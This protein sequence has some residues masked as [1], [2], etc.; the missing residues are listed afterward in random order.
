MALRPPGAGPWRR[1][2]PYL[3]RYRRAF[4]IGFLCVAAATTLQ[5]LSPWVL[6]IGSC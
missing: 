4:A 5:Q 2:W 6:T 1:L 3:A